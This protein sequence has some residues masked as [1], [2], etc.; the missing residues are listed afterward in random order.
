MA[1]PVAGLQIVDIGDPSDPTLPGY[2][3]L[4]GQAWD[5]AVSGHT[6]CVASHVTGLQIVDLSDP[7]HPAVLGSHGAPS[8]T[9]DVAVSGNLAHLAD[10]DS[11]LLIV[12]VSTP[13]TPPCS[14]PSR[15]TR[16]P[17]PSPSEA[18]SPMRPPDRAGLPPRRG[19]PD[20]PWRSE[21]FPERERLPSS[22][23]ALRWARRWTAPQ[24]VRPRT[25]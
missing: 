17:A 3:D 25:S 12:D 20:T 11:G 10:G 7:T 21:G 1:G 5:L 8:T 9:F 14:P 19:R 16:G 6:A 22:F 4:P 18:T 23:R 24:G 13:P 2:A 15:P